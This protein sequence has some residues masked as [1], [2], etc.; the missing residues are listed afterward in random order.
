[1]RYLVRWSSNKGVSMHRA[2]ETPQEA[3]AALIVLHAAAFY[4]AH[5]TLAH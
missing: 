5:I 4:S 1:M 3:L 2:F